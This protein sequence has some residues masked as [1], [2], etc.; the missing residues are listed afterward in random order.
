MSYL[1]DKEFLYR[2]IWLF[3]CLRQILI[4]W[5]LSGVL[6]YCWSKILITET[7]NMEL[8]N[9]I[10][11]QPEIWRDIAPVGTEPFDT[12]YQ[13]GF[14]YFL[15]NEV[16]GVIIYHPFLDGLKI[17][18]NIIPEKRG[19]TAFDAVEESIQVVFDMG[20]K[21]IYAEIPPRFKHIVR[22][23]RQLQFVP[24]EYDGR[25]ILVRRNLDS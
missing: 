24:C 1:T 10:L 19:K 7:D 11:C 21:S 25:D 17:H 22:F 23:A 9:S 12:P 16:D 5:K 3:G 6:I 20:C 13:P 15:V 14:L 8:V 2:R 4:I 18:P